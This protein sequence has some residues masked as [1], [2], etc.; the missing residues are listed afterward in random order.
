MPRLT[1]RQ[2]ITALVLAA[3]LATP[4]AAAAAPSAWRPATSP[5]LL[6]QMWTILTTLWSPGGG[7]FVTP[8]AGCRMDPNGSGCA[9][10]T[11]GAGTAVTPNADAGCRMDPDGRCLGG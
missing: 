3:A 8:D 1:L 5:S 7:A 11:T 6:G 2:R 9:A 10:G 4:W